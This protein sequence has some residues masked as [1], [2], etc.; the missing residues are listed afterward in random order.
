[1]G[2][3]KIAEIVKDQKP[4]VLPESARVREAAEVMAERRIG[5][6]MV[7]KNDRLVGI[8][9]ERDMTVRIVSRGVNP[10]VT[11]L[12]EAMT[13]K[14]DTLTSEDSVRAALH[15]M[16]E[17][18]YRHLPVVDGERLAGIVSIRDLYATVMRQLEDNILAVADR[19]MRG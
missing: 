7:V 3:Q 1:M 10:D 16:A 18:G 6:V 4:V 19:V 2:S 5:A 11:T 9:T 15:M 14:P 8:F 12:G 13:A 17:N